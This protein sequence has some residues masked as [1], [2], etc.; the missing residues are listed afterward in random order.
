MRL[1]YSRL[2]EILR[3]LAATVAAMPAEDIAHRET[4]ADAAKALH[5]PLAARLGHEAVTFAFVTNQSD[6][7][8]QSNH[9]LRR[10]RSADQPDFHG[11][12]PA[13]RSELRMDRTSE[14]LA[15]FPGPIVLRSS[16][17]KWL[18]L[19]ALAGSFTAGGVGDAMNSAGISDWIGVAFFGLGAVAFAWMALFANF[20][21]ILDEDGFGWRGGRLSERW[22][23]TDVG[24]FAVV[25]YA[26]QM[27]GAS[28]RK[29]IGFNDKRSAKSLSQT[30]GEGITSAMT[31]RD[32]FIFD[33][34][35]FSSFSLPMEDLARLLS[36]WQQRAMALHDAT[37]RQ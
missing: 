3:D 1:E 37:P 18:G 28:L 29:R 26:P 22:R 2:A 25:E 21:M 33:A 13:S 9:W 23:W 15:R 4:L 14:L 7:T 34:Y 16:K 24:D 8:A 11:L 32:C 6:R 27:R 12:M 17:W 19:A 5:R 20:R 35:G 10:H 36:Q 30:M 31:G